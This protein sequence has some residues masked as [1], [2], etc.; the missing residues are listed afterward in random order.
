VSDDT[1]SLPEAARLLNVTRRAVVK[2][3]ERGALAVVREEWHGHQRRRY[4][5]RADVD[6]YIAARAD[7]AREGQE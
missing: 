7:R 1:L 4:V 2:M 6:A 3:I 5:R